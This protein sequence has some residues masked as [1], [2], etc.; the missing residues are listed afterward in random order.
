LKA[1]GRQRHP[2]RIWITAMGHGK[3]QDVVTNMANTSWLLRT[4]GEG[5]PEVFVIQAFM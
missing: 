5:C 3:G 2:A 4:F 1:D